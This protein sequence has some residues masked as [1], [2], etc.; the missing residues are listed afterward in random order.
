[1]IILSMVSLLIG[2]VLGQ[3]FRVI[4]LMPAT[5]IVLVLA[6]GTGAA[7]AHTAWMFVLMTATTATSMQ[8]GYFIG[9]GIRHLVAAALSSRSASLNSTAASTAARHPARLSLAACR[10][11]QAPSKTDVAGASAAAG[12]GVEIVKRA[13]AGLAL[14]RL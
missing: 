4:V 10:S 7:H 2:A 13:S 11:N 1:M 8:I 12:S 6:V 3:G 14:D 9:I 5:A